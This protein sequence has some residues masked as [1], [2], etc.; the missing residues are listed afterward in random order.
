MKTRRL[1]S[2]P[3]WTNLKKTVKR[4]NFKKMSEKPVIKEFKQMLLKY[5][6][7]RLYMDRMITSISKLTKS[8]LQESIP[9]ADVDTLL[10]HLNT[11]LSQAPEFNTSLSVGTPISSMLAWTLG[12]KYGFDAY[13]R[14]RINKMFG[15]VL[16]VY[17]KFL[18]SPE[19]RYV[20]NDKPN[21][22]FSPKALKKLK[23]EQYVY[24]PD[25]KYY[26]FKSW[27]D[28]FTR[29]LKPGMRPIASP[30]DNRVIVSACDSTVYRIRHNVKRFSKFWLKTQPYSVH[31]M[32]ANDD[33][34]INKFVGGTIYQAFLNPFNYHRWHSP[35]DGTIEKAF[36][37]PGY[38]FV[39]SDDVGQDPNIQDGSE[40]FLT[41]IQTR[42]LIYIKADYKPLGTVCV[43]PTG[44]IEIS[45]C[46]I[47]PKIKPGYKV[48]KGE[49]LGFFAYGGSTH[50]VFF[51][52]DVIKKIV[53][54][55]NEFIKMGEKLA[56]AN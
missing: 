43:M 24:D 42:A 26:G 28:F 16:A 31:D 23:I 35:I 38:Y 22:W 41:N 12:S 36:V 46:N 55:K 25:A 54:K 6:V 13:R 33:Y 14:E 29:H 44:M 19:S 32:L 37:Q 52:P 39:Q 50:C 53:P 40:G 15:K 20:L 5:P 3:K 56:I 45:S 34:Y 49:E 9:P 1:K 11:L 8:Q 51:E 10:S 2:H 4:R 21:G 7:E 17:K 27:N 47:H 30:D 48:K 18:D